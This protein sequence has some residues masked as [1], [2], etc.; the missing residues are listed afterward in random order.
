M[1]NTPE[2]KEKRVAQIELFYDLIYVYAISRLTM[3]VEEPV[4]GI[5]PFSGFMTYL[6]VCFVILQ[7][8]LY[9]TNYVNRYGQWKWYEYLFTAVNMI[10]AVYMANTI[11]RDWNEMTLAFNLAMLVMLLCVLAMYFIQLCLRQKDTGAAKNSLI[12]LS[13]D[14][15]LYFAAFLAAALHADSAVIWMDITAVLAGAF[16]PF[17]IRGHFDISIISFPHLAERFELLTIVTFGEAVVGMTEYF[18]V[19]HFSMRPILVFAVILTLFGCYMVQLHVLCSHRRVERALRLMFTHYFIVISLNLITIGF[20]FLEN[21]T[22][23]RMFTACL[24]ICAL[25]MFFVCI[26]LNSAYYDKQY[27]LPGSDIGITAVSLA[28]GAVIMMTGR[29]NTYLFL[30]GEWIAV[31]G[32]FLMLLWKWKHPERRQAE[33]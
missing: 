7:A 4:N 15:I 14:C 24:V 25:I 27:V 2:V 29:H 30:T 26:L 13:V 16:L 9:L 8:W 32:I 6:V 18:D 1:S 5:I 20:H 19:R 31:F 12:I 10:G 33:T 22:A 11:S 28:A 21:P 23:G 17:F 3:L